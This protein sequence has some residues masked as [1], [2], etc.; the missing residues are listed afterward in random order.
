MGTNPHDRTVRRAALPEVL[1]GDDVA[2][3][4]DIPA[5]EATRTLAA[6]RFGPSFLVGGRPA[7]L[8]EAFLAHLAGEARTP[9]S[10]EV[11]P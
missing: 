5:A 1:F 4:L 11:L 2:I 3:I 7:V 8:R 6:G 10:R 9:A